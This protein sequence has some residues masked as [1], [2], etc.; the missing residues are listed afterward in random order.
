MRKIFCLLLLLACLGCQSIT[1]ITF[2]DPVK[3][4]EYNNERCAFKVTFDIDKLKND[5]N[6]TKTDGNSTKTY[7]N[8]IITN[9]INKSTNT[10][11]TFSLPL[12]TLGL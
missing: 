11:P 8:V 6:F 1:N 10:S 5:G 2:I 7:P 12:N 3:N 9:S 4:I